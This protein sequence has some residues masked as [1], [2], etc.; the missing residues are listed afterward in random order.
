M[1]GLLLVP[2]NFV[3]A[4]VLSDHRPLSD[5]WFWIAVVTGA[6]VFSLITWYSSK[7]LMR[8]GNQ[9]M[10]IA[11]LGCSLG[12]LFLN[13]TIDLELPVVFSVFFTLPILVSFLVGSC[14]FDHRQ[15]DRRHWTISAQNRLWLFWNRFCIG[16]ICSLDWYLSIRN[17][18]RA[19]FDFCTDSVSYL[20]D[21]VSLWCPDA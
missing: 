8:R 12:T 20:F 3:M 16:R 6:S 15:W 21:D 11:V 7:A 2:I 4:C 19:S 18:F 13:R 5:P 1:I 14:A 10:F 9:P 17:D